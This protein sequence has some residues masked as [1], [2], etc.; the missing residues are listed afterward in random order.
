LVVRVCGRTAGSRSGGRKF[1]VAARKVPKRL[2]DS[3][4]AA[5]SGGVTQGPSRRGALASVKVGHKRQEGWCPWFATLGNTEPSAIETPKHPSGGFCF[6][7]RKRKSP[8][9]PLAGDPDEVPGRRARQHVLVVGGEKAVETKPG[10]ICPALIE[11]SWR[12]D[13]V[14]AQPQGRRR[15]ETSP[16]WLQAKQDVERVRNPEDGRCRRLEP[17]G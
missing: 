17:A 5:E 7:Q 10:R 3:G 2:D 8:K 15:D 9:F 16:P 14:R 6:L 4:D 13:E 1:P 12:A 11:R